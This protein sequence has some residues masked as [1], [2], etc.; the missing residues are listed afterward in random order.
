MIGVLLQSAMARCKRGGIALAVALC[1]L[2]SLQAQAGQ[3]SADLKI[4]VTG[5]G[6]APARVFCNSNVGTGSFGA[7]VTVVC[8]TGAIVGITGPDSFRP[9]HGGAYRYLL[10]VKPDEQLAGAIDALTGI[11]NF[12]AWQLVKV[13][14]QEYVE[15][16]LGW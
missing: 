16:T 12:A 1:I 3:A 2:Q 11:E 14:N 15:L 4:L 6:A 7:T 9:S 13:G 8:S 10:Q 5:A